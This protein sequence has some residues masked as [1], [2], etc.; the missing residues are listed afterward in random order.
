MYTTLDTTVTKCT[1]KSKLRPGRTREGDC[2]FFH[3]EPQHRSCS[4]G[5]REEQVL[6]T[7][8][9]SRRERGCHSGRDGGRISYICI[10]A[11]C[12]TRS[13]KMPCSDI[14]RKKGAATS[15]SERKRDVRLFAHRC[16]CEYR[17]RDGRS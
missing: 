8:A 16:T 5:S 3:R 1:S 14:S 11:R 12:A 13:L 10:C 9:A 4:S 7:A 17:L 15:Y 6:H 2:P